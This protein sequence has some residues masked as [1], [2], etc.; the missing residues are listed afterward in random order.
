[1]I[2]QSGPIHAVTARVELSISGALTLKD[3]RAVVKSLIERLKGRFNLSVAD[4]DGG[5]TGAARAV[6]GVATVSNSP[7]Q[8]NEMAQK[9][10][11]FIAE[12]GRADVMAV[13]YGE[14]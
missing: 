4:L 7:S 11:G 5:E 6:I 3:R 12:D 9:A 13:E 1:M 8:A 10:V 14:L 2:G